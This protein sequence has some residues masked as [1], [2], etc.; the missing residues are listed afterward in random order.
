[1]PTIL[2]STLKA[3]ATPQEPT[4]AS[5]SAT[6]DDSTALP[7]LLKAAATPQEPIA[8][9]PAPDDGS[10]ALPPPIRSTGSLQLQEPP[11]RPLP[12]PDALTTASTMP[13][14]ILSGSAKVIEMLQRPVHTPPPQPDASTNAS[15]APT[16]IFSGSKARHRKKKHKKARD[17]AKSSVQTVDTP[18]EPFITADTVMDNTPNE[19]FI[20]A[21]TVQS[22]FA[23]LFATET[24][25]P[26]SLERDDRIVVDPP[27]PGSR[28]VPT[29]SLRESIHPAVY[30]L[31]AI[32]LIVFLGMFW[33]W[34]SRETNRSSD[35][36]EAPFPALPSEF[37]SDVEPSRV[38][39][40]PAS[41]VQKT[42]PPD[43]ELT[44]LKPEPVSEQDLLSIP[45]L[46]T[47][48]QQ[49]RHNIYNPSRP[50]ETR[51]DAP[52][53]RSPLPMPAPPTPAPAH[54]S[55]ATPTLELEPAATLTPELEPTATPAP[56]FVEPAAAPAPEFEPAAAPASAPVATSPDTPPWL[57]QMR[58][59]LLDCEGF[60]CREKV[61]KQYCTSQWENLPECK[62]RSL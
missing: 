11:P 3:T 45:S 55:A 54:E 51:G 57:E 53:S 32:I 39:S 33:Q 15:T 17:H 42:P 52:I 16:M 34:N 61:R 21:D 38:L 18:I 49:G 29:Q 22:E 47:N 43:P 2:L 20:A 30:G 37:P 4:A 10:T 50:A 1:M 25:P 31:A 24:F 41:S 48:Q 56:E 7:Y 40:A 58:D 23:P 46:P 60:F 19:P 13:T 35:N 8:A 26:I 36:V 59:D 28:P 14:M 44:L 27:Y 5:P 62:S 12:Q 6:D 9:A